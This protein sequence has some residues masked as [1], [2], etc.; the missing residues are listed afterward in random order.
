MFISI[1]DIK[2]VIKEADLAILTGGDNDIIFE[3]IN[4]SKK[5]IASKIQHRYDPN[6]IFIDIN[7]WQYAKIY[8]SG[9]LVQYTEPAYVSGVYAKDDRVSYCG[10][11]YKALNSSKS[12]APTD[13]DY[14]E[15][16]QID[17]VDIKDKSLFYCIKQAYEV[18]PD[19]TEIWTKGDNRDSLIKGY[20][21]YIAIY[22]LFTR[23]NP[24]NVPEWA[25]QKRD[26]AVAHL[27]RISKGTDTA[28]L[29]IYT[30]TDTGQTFVF[31]SET[32]REILY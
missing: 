16:V 15:R 2:Q 17:S 9:N 30:D 13:A 12:I 3:K 1:E 19:N 4:F 28:D 10:Y 25:M 6:Q 11:I 31:G 14:W 24:R 23:C 7:S 21:I 8:S 32:S 18:Y 5:L 27:D 26:E 20:C 22:E 29:P